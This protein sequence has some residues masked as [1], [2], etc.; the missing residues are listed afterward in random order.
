MVASIPYLL[1]RQR[2]FVRVH[3]RAHFATALMHDSHVPQH[4]RYFDVVVA[5]RLLKDRERTVMQ[6]CL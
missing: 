1:D 6:V 2:T 4:N 5:V 3:C